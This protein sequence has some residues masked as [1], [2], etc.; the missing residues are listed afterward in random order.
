MEK[1][2]KHLNTV[3]DTL[4]RTN[5]LGS[6]QSLAKELSNLMTQFSEIQNFQKKKFDDS[7]DNDFMEL[8]FSIFSSLHNQDWTFTEFDTAFTEQLQK[9]SSIIWQS[10]QTFLQLT[11]NDDTSP[12]QNDIFCS[13][14]EKKLIST[15]WELDMGVY[16]PSLGVVVEDRIKQVLT[17]LSSTGELS[18]QVFRID[19]DLL[20]ELMRNLKMALI[21]ADNM[22]KEI[23][24]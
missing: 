23:A 11:K 19:P 16:L 10:Y 1:N 3:L 18:K 5:H 13:I 4:R 22:Q 12:D 14:Y 17:L 8:I 9:F 6:E 15:D 24:V 20:E 21:S 2:F 7:V